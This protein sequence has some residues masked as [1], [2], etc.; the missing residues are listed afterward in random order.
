MVIG[1]DKM[2]ID[3]DNILLIAFNTN[4]D[5]ADMA[6]SESLIKLL[7]MYKDKKF[8][9]TYKDEFKITLEAKD[10]ALEDVI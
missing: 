5:V 3:A 7:K 2:G 1:L 4:I 9:F 8:V 6:F 10:I